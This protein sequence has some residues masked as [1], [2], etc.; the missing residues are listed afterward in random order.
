MRD[1]AQSAGLDDKTLLRLG[2]RYAQT[3]LGLRIGRGAAAFY[4]Q[5]GV[6]FIAATV[7]ILKPKPN[8]IPPIDLYREQDVHVWG[9]T[10]HGGLI[11]WF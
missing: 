9:V 11:Y 5:G 10:G 7:L 8:V 6:S 2:Y 3:Q 1:L 4:L